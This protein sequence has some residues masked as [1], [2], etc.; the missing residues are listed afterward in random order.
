MTVATTQNTESNTKNISLTQHPVPLFFSAPIFVLDDFVFEAPLRVGIFASW[1]TT[2]LAF[3][4]FPLPGFPMFNNVFVICI[5]ASPCS[6][7]MT[8][9]KGVALALLSEQAK[10]A[11]KYPHTYDCLILKQNSTN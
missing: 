4:D 3:D 6:D 8:V 2:S 10:E 7:G 9:I 1:P 5:V 11:F